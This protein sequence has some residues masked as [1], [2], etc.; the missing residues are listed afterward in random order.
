MRPWP[1]P[2]SA[3]RTSMPQVL[4]VAHGSD[5]GAK[6]MGGRMDGAAGE[7]DLAGAKFSAR[8]LDASDHTDASPAFEQQLG[9][10]AYRSR[11]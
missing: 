5:A 6:E 9:S 2:A 8:A 1:T 7:D 4:E 10:P 3:E 11:S